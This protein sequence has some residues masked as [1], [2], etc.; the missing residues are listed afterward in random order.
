[1]QSKLIWFINIVCFC[2]TMTTV[3]Y[4]ACDMLC[5]SCDQKGL[6]QDIGMLVLFNLCSLVFLY[7]KN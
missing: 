2:L 4:A 6:L 7:Y 5:A 3:P 1:M